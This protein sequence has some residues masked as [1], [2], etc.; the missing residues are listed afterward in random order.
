VLCSYDLSLWSRVDRPLANDSQ[1]SEQIVVFGTHS[2]TRLDDHPSA[3]ENSLTHALHALH[4]RVYYV[5][6]D[7][8]Q[9]TLL[10]PALATRHQRGNT[11][12]EGQFY[13]FFPRLI[14]CALSIM[15]HQAGA[16]A[17]TRRKRAKRLHDRKVTKTLP[18]ESQVA[19]A[20][21]E[22]LQSRRPRF[23]HFSVHPVLAPPVLLYPFTLVVSILPA[24][25]FTHSLCSIVVNE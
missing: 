5:V 3:F 18:R 16:N 15:D 25:L 17:L 8:Q 10:R 20:R 22:N 13:R 19:T 6:V 11:F 7:E 24:I 12:I 9:R 2:H 21:L 23:V 1:R 4:A 14:S